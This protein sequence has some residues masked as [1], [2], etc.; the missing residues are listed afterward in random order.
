MF[1]MYPWTNAIKIISLL[2][3]ET[4]NPR[5]I[6]EKNIR[7]IPIEGHCIN[8]WPVL[9][10]SPKTPKSSLGTWQQNIVWYCVRDRSTLELNLSYIDSRSIFT[11]LPFSMK[12]LA[13]SRVVIKSN[14]SLLILSGYLGELLTIIIHI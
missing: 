12:W 5:P 10:G 7:Q 8:I 2:L 13:V 3:L 6:H 1:I 9:P 4:H 11:H 14:S